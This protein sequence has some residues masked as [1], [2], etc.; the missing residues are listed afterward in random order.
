VVKMLDIKSIATKKSRL[1]PAEIQ[2]LRKKLNLTTKE[3]ASKIGVRPETVSRW[4]STTSP[5]PMRLSAE[6]LLRIIVIMPHLAK[7]LDGLG[8]EPQAASKFIWDE[9]T[10]TLTNV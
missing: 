3:L 9:K 6:R 7:V 10:E 4:E 1:T 5:K 2:I 8:V